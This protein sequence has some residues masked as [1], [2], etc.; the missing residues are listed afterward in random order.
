MHITHDQIM[1]PFTETLVDTKVSKKINREG[2]VPVFI[3]T[4]D[5]EYLAAKGVADLNDRETRVAIAN[6]SEQTL[7]LKKGQVVAICS[8]F[9]ENDYIM[10]DLPE[11]VPTNGERLVNNIIKEKSTNKYDHDQVDL[12]LVK[13][14]L[15]DLNL[16]DDIQIGIDDM[17]RGSL[18]ELIRVLSHFKE[19][20][21]PDIA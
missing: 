6:F 12:V 20:F 21:T 13:K 5:N 11:D 18:K 1:Y 19:L 8:I 4:L 10:R 14:M 9:D 7:S 15:K 3:Q 2:N 16:P 17:D